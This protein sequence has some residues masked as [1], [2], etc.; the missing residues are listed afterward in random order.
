MTAALDLFGAAAEDPD[1]A[2]VDNVCRAVL[3]YA[4]DCARVW[5]VSPAKVRQEIARRIAAGKSR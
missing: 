1:A 2:A 4:D 5:E 3:A